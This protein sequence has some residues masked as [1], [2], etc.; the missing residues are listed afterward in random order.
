MKADHHVADVQAARPCESRAP[1]EKLA[2]WWAHVLRL[3]QSHMTQFIPDVSLHL[4][5]FELCFPLVRSRIYV[6][7]IALPFLALAQ[8]Q[9]EFLAQVRKH[10]SRFIRG[11]RKYERD[12]NYHCI[13]ALTN[14]SH[15]C[16][17]SILS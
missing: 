5:K 1:A 7:V 16:S 15:M 2:A 8:L 3:E 10:W 12:G 14:Y 6:Y 17:I 11:K 13:R 9:R 4:L